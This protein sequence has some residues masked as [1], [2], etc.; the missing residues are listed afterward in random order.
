MTGCRISKIKMTEHQAHDW[1]AHFKPGDNQ[2]VLGAIYDDAYGVEVPSGDY[3]PVK[4]IR[5]SERG[6]CDLVE[7]E[8]K[9]MRRE[10]ELDA[11]EREAR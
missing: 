8:M 7:E 6:F 9:L 5:D 2:I 3:I 10:A 11:I 1:A 4:L